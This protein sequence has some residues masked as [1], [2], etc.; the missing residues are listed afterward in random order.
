MLQIFG[1]SDLTVF[2]LDLWSAGDSVYSREIVWKFGDSPENVFDMYGDSCENS[3][4]F[5]DV[6]IISS[7]ISSVCGHG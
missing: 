4:D 5:L 2:L 1:S 3:F 7:P 6:V